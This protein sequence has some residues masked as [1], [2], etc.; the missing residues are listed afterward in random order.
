MIIVILIFLVFLLFTLFKN[1]ENF[2]QFGFKDNNNYSSFQKCC[3]VNGCYSNKC[4]KFLD[5]LNHKNHLDGKD[6]ETDNLIFSNDS[7]SIMVK[8]DQIII[9]PK[10]DKETKNIISNG[11][12]KFQIDRK[13][14]KTNKQLIGHLSYPLNPITYQLYHM[15]DRLWHNYYI[16]KDGY[17]IHFHSTPNEIQNNDRIYIKIN[18]ESKYYFIFKKL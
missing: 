12:N 18:D 13:F 1:Q 14:D 7:T 2:N 15:K 8:D 3:K 11:F 16:V 10:L 6:K 17:F 5:Y 4:K 9:M